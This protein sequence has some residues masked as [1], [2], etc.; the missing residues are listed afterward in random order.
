[1]KDTTHFRSGRPAALFG[2]CLALGLSACNRPDGQ[3]S[4][5][6]AAA[7]PKES[8]TLGAAID[9]T[10]ITA[11]V[12]QRLATDARLQ[13]A[14]VDVSTNNGV[15]SLTGTAP[16]NDTRL[17][18]EELARSVENVSGVDNQINAPSALQGAAT[19]AKQ[20]VAAAG[21][22]I[23]DASIT[24]KVKAQLAA[25]QQIKAGDLDVDTENGVVSLT[26]KVSSPQ[27]RVRAIEIAR[28]TDG[29]K[30]VEAE[31]LKVVQPS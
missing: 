29:V 17:A 13:Q 15:V 4:D 5:A 25:D 21:G 11:K 14:T 18:A 19:Q 23:S 9:D 6:E 20:A 7:A 30:D 1:M 28:K 27:A 2:L 31:A 26:G 22:E 24:A 12:K 3:M 10:G 8:A 16:D